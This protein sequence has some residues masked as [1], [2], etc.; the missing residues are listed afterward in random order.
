QEGRGGTLWVQTAQGHIVR[1]RDGRF[2]NIPPEDGTVRERLSDLVVDSAGTVWT[3]NVAGLWKTQADRLVRVAPGTLGAPVTSIV[4]R[5]DGSLWLG[6]AHAGIFRVASDG[7]VTKVASDPG[8]ESDS[9]V[10]IAED[11]G[12]TLWIAGLRHL[13]RWHERPIEVKAEGRP[14]SVVRIVDDAAEGSVYAQASSGN[15]RVDSARATLIG[16]PVT[17]ASPNAFIAVW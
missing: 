17:W 9:I 7:G 12:G 3:G 16:A 6:T 14:L 10:A 15:Y 5:R 2:T 11:R 1:F 8:I 4:R 13:W